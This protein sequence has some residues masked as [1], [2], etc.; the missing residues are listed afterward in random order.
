MPHKRPSPDFSTHPIDQ[1]PTF[2]NPPSPYTWMTTISYQECSFS[3]I[4]Q[5]HL[6]HLISKLSLLTSLITFQNF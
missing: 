4:D 6:G 2:I 5:S 1:W 3:K